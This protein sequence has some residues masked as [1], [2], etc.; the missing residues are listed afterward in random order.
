MLAYPEFGVEDLVRHVGWTAEEVR[1]A[2]DEC[3]RLALVRSSWEKPGELLPVSPEVGLQALLA[4]QEIELLEQTRQIMASRLEVA[5]LIDEY[6]TMQQER[7]RSDAER[8]TGIDE[9][10]TRIEELTAGCD[11]ELMAFQPGGGQE[12]EH[13]RA[14]RQL[15]K[16]LFARGVRMRTV[17]LDSLYNDPPSVDYAHW[18]VDRG[19]EV[20][21]TAS[22]PSRMIIF[23]DSHALLPVDPEAS[24]AEAVVLSAPAMIVTVTALFE[25]VWQKATPLSGGRTPPAD[26]DGHELT[27]QENVVLQLLGDGHTDEAV[28]R[29]LG[30][31]V[32]TGRRITAEL[33]ARLGAKSRFQAGAR[34]AERGWL[35]RRIR[36]GV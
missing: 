24:G 27:G 11:E 22:L 5:R 33:M 17:Y 3:A 20:R 29:K 2:L 18:L 34:A 15:S 23:G 7:R 30:V 36:R 8:L 21:T 4:R 35:G 32:R 28:A 1:S 9:I 6:T 13:R 31:S 26:T 25:H 14:S 16:G 10:R 12:P 19:A